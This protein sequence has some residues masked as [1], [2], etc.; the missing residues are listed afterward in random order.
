MHAESKRAGTLTIATALLLGLAACGQSDDVG[1]GAGSTEAV[2]I[3]ESLAPFGDGFPN[4]GDPCRTLCESAATV[5]C[6]DDSAR[7]VGCPTAEAAAALGG[8]TVANIEGVT[9][10]S[11]PLGDA[12]AGMR[13]NGPPPPPEGGDALVP[14]TDYN[15]TSDIPCGFNGAPPTSTCPA[16]VKR[17]WNGPDTALVEVTKPD[18]LKRAIFFE[19]GA[20]ISADSSQSDGSAAYD[21]AATLSGDETTIRYGPETYVVV[22]ALVSGG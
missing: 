22:D 18:G 9:L 3:P 17:N 12:N 4:A 21:F 6:L 14:G 13:E 5:N 20:A 10:V 8:T 15:A 1:D 11:V 16:G 7:L 19:G 2:A